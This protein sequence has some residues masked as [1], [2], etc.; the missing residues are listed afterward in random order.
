[1]K[2]INILLKDYPNDVRCYQL[3]G[4]LTFGLKLYDKSLEC[5]DKLLEMTN[6][7]ENI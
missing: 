6:V 1:L 4:E 2:K 3:K 5:Y 7:V